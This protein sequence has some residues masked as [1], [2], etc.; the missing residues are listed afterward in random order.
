MLAQEEVGWL[1]AEATVSPAEAEI[2]A[3]AVLSGWVAA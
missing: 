2:D 3:G 1:A